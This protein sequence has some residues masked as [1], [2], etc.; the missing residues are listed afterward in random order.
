MDLY[1]KK[2]DSVRVIPSLAFQLK[3]LREWLFCKINIVKCLSRSVL[4]LF[5]YSVENVKAATISHEP[6]RPVFPFFS[7]ISIHLDFDQSIGPPCIMFYK[8]PQ[9]ILAEFFTESYLLI[10]H[11]SEKHSTQ[12]QFSPHLVFLIHTIP[13]KITNKGT[14]ETTTATINVVL[15]FGF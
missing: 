2:L 3:V 8:E 10:K 14:A 12:I 1:E 11:Y 13:T 6:M 7:S 9:V 4:D 5:S 15:L